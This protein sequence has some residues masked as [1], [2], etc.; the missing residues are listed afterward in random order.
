MLVALTTSVSG[1]CYSLQDR[2]PPVM[3]QIERIE[4]FPSLKFL[5]SR[6]YNPV[7]DV[8]AVANLLKASMLPPGVL[9]NCRIS[10][11]RKC[12]I[13]LPEAIGMTSAL[14]C[15]A[16][17]S[18]LLDTF[19]VSVVLLHCMHATVLSQQGARCRP[20][21]LKGTELDGGMDMRIATQTE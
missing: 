3:N 4:A 16:C 17:L 15:E 11:E 7:R 12:C 10:K 19:Q 14:C 8:S 6:T 5:E 18:S 20:D 9:Q 21:K 2:R 1:P 13:T